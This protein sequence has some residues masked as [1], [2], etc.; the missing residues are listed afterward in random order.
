M[1]WS[2]TSSTPT[3]TPASISTSSL[4]TGSS[5]SDHSSRPNAGAI[6]GGVA[7][8][9][10]GVA[11]LVAALYLLIR[12]RKRQQPRQ[13]PQQPQSHAP[14]SSLPEYTLE[15]AASQPN[16]LDSRHMP[17]E[18]SDHSVNRRYELPTASWIS[19]SSSWPKGPF[20]DLGYY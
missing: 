3:S 5:T 16:E 9:V 17:V 19:I 7:G 15:K 1:L 6:G 18:L 8:G 10:V 13:Q 2:G 12:Y 14:P 11:A 20:A 4:A